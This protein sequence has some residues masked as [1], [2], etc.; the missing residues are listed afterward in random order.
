MVRTVRSS[1]ARSVLGALAWGLAV[2]PALGCGPPAEARAQEAP[3]AH[4]ESTAHA[5]R[6][7]APLG[8]IERD[9]AMVSV[10]TTPPT[11]AATT[12]DEVPTRLGFD[13][14]LYDPGG[15]AL[16]AFHE[17]LRRAALGEGQA[18]IAVYGAS[19]VAGDLATG[20]LRRMLQRQF[21]DAGHGFVLPA[22]P[23]PHYRHLDITIESN[24]RLWQAQRVRSGMTEPGRFGL[25]GVAVRASSARAFGRVRV[26]S[27]SRFELFY[28]REPG[29][30]SMEVRIDRRVV[31]RIPT[32]AA[33]AGPDY[34]VFTV[35]D[36]PHT[37]EVRARGDGPITI[38]GV[39]VEREVPG[40]VLDTLGING[41]R[42]AGQLLW[43]EA[44]WREHIRRRAPN[45]VVLAY[46]TNES[47]DEDQPIET[48]ES[49]LRRIVARVRSAVPEASCLLVG[50][51]DRPVAKGDGT[52]AERP[53]TAMIIDVQRRV[54]VEH[55]CAFFDLVAFGGGPMHI[56]DWATRDPAWA[57]RDHV[58][59]TSLGYTRL[60]QVLY[61]SLLGG[62]ADLTA[63]SAAPGA[64]HSPLA[65][66]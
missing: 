58:H 35:P 28:W 20:T 18:R 24:H 14:P 32:A 52:Y 48:Y 2:A 40:V 49:D 59:F 39:A 64:P 54:A 63:S 31:R 9:A 22:H 36:A 23:W 44:L 55:G 13:V 50:P 65:S 34:A 30:G 38:F 3:P 10:P 33:E 4:A 19:H 53:R 56:L 1:A 21:G 62:A 57:Q 7:S 37:F 42:A 66:R 26:R 43:D 47:G 61:S 6:R 17:A 60:G 45:L 41:A 5:M 51:S 11:P 8:S 16:R 29:G 25:A 15:T 12:G 27:A 46:G